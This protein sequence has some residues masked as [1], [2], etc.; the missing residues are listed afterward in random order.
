MRAD[1]EVAEAIATRKE[2]RGSVRFHLSSAQPEILTQSLP[3]ATARKH[4]KHHS[5]RLGFF[6]AADSEVAQSEFC[7]RDKNG[8]ACNSRKNANT[9]SRITGQEGSK[10]CLTIPSAPPRTAITTMAT[11]AKSNRPHPNAAI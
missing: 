8:T 9:A 10:R 7:L 1:I 3:L 5:F 11:K 2:S 4:C 6:V